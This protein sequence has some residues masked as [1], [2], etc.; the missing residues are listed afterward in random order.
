MEFL[1][2]QITQ[3]VYIS[4]VNISEE[5]LAKRLEKKAACQQATE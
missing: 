5:M 2:A 1:M 3:P 4:I